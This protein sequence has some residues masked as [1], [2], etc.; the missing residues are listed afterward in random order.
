MSSK[1]VQINIKF[2]TDIVVCFLLSQS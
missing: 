2:V 1:Q